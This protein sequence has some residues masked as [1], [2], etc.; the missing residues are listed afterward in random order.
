MCI[1]ESTNDTLSAAEQTVLRD[2]AAAEF[3]THAFA[4]RANADGI[5]WVVLEPRTIRADLMRI[6]ICR[7]DPCVM[8]MIEDSAARR[9]ICSTADVAGAVAFVRNAS[10]QALL[11]VMN[12]HPASPVL[13]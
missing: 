9:Q 12:A 5:A 8:V 13:Q 11:A 3:P 6:T 4:V 10:D 2:V 1:G 7:I